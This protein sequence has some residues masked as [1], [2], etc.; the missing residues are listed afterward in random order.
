LSGLCGHA[1]HEQHRADAHSEL[2]S[3]P[4]DPGSVGTRRENIARCH[5]KS[6]SSKEKPIT[7]SP[8]RR[9]AFVAP[10]TSTSRSYI[11][12]RRAIG[13]TVIKGHTAEQSSLPTKARALLEERDFTAQDRISVKSVYPS[14]DDIRR[15]QRHFRAIRRHEP[16]HSI[17]SSARESN[18][19]DT[20]RPSSLAVFRLIVNG[21]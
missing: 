16:V 4:A 11:R 10:H 8:F 13:V 15:L 17:I 7:H 9:L 6:A 18:E 5:E 14:A 20:V 19:G 21:N 3:D 2:A 1:S 12:D